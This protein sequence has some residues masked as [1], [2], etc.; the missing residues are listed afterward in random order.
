MALVGTAGEFLAEIRLVSEWWKDGASILF[1]TSDGRIE[2]PSR[3]RLRNPASAYH[4]IDV[5][6][7]VK[8][9]S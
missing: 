9:T 1:N 8:Q 6:K 4:F 5:G 2:N 3:S 7:M